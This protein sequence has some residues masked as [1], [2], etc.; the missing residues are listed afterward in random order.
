ML[1]TVILC[2]TVNNGRDKICSEL[3][4][5]HIIIIQYMSFAKSNFCLLILAKLFC[6]EYSWTLHIEI[7]S[8]YLKVF[9]KDM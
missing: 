8:A 5:F 2:P 6:L 9:L 7:A 3:Y 4:I 1:G